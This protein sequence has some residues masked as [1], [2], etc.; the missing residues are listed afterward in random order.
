MES[1]LLTRRH[2]QQAGILFLR[3]VVNGFGMLIALWHP[4]LSS[5]VSQ[6]L[7]SN[8][9]PFPNP[10]KVALQPRFKSAR[11][12]LQLY[13][14]SMRWQHMQGRYFLLDTSMLPGSWTLVTLQ[15]LLM[16]RRRCWNTPR[17]TR[18]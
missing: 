8:G 14:N 4:S 2:V 7:I 13:V 9:S 17:G 3:E 15:V 16:D 5:V 10:S 11:D 12:Q 18:L 1:R 6:S